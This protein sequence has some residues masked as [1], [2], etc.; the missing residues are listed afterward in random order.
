MSKVVESCAARCRPD[1]GTR[2]QLINRTATDKNDTTLI[3]YKSNNEKKRDTKKR[4][5]ARKKMKIQAQY[6]LNI[7]MD[8]LCVG[9]RTV[10]TAFFGAS[11]LYY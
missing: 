1:S 5:L 2:I 10:L 4:K 6:T 7:K 8:R 9:N 11:N 3:Q